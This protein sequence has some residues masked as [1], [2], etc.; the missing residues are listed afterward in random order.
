M[1][2][3]IAL[4][5]KASQIQELQGVKERF[6]STVAQVTRSLEERSV[7]WCCPP[8]VPIPSASPP[9]APR[10]ILSARPRP[11]PVPVRGGGGAPPPPRDALEGEKD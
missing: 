9:R 11:V 1:K 5:E 4:Q 3:E 10:P 8:R 6:E 7:L 2:A